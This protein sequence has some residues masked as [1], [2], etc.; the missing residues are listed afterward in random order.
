MM[1]AYGLLVY[2]NLIMVI[3]AQV[4][5]IGYVKKL[6]A[7]IMYFDTY[8]RTWA[9]VICARDDHGEQMRIDGCTG[10]YLIMKCFLHVV[11]SSGYTY[12]FSRVSECHVDLRIIRYIL[13][14]W[15]LDCIH[16]LHIKSS[17]SQ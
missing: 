4:I 17:D 12:H 15:R 8:I 16:Y 14:I 5:I 7:F 6:V 13:L 1:L 10:T 3:W 11:S 9:S 2:V